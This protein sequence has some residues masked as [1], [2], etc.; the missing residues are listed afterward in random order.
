MERFRTAILFLGAVYALLPPPVASAHVMQPAGTTLVQD[1]GPYRLAL[2]MSL[3]S[4]LPSPLSVQVAPEQPFPGVVAITIALVS[5]GASW[6]TLTPAH[7]ISAQGTVF[8]QFPIA[9]PGDYEL[10][11]QAAGQ[12][13]SAE[14]RVPITAAQPPAAW[15]AWL[16]PAGLGM[17]VLFLGGAGVLSLAMHRRRLLVSART[18]LALTGSMAISAFVALV[19]LVATQFI[20]ATATTP[21]STSVSPK[22][23]NVNAEVH[24]DVNPIGAG[25]PMD[26]SIALTNGTGGQ[27]VDDVVPNHNALMH[28][29]IVSA[30]REFFQHAYPARTAPGRYLATFSPD[31]PGNYTAYVEVLRQTDSAPQVFARTLSVGADAASPAG[32]ATGDGEEVSAASTTSPANI[33]PGLPAHLTF[34][35]SA[36]GRPIGLAPFLDTAADI[37]VVS[38]DGGVFGHIPATDLATGNLLD[39]GATIPM[40]G[41]TA[42]PLGSTVNFTCTFP[43]AGRY[44]LW[45][46]AKRADSGVVITASKWLDVGAAAADGSTP[47]GSTAPL[48]S[49]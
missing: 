3:A 46:G 8:A 24:T 26:L 11:L 36:S 29:F 6:P 34:R 47:G 20:P 33:R 18:N 22:G 35:F 27:L 38:S 2:T 32:S 30:D 10:L 45:V 28:V 44:K 1:L 39:G 9:N 5:A 7:V 14:A 40:S 48:T 42:T 23:S 41:P 37:V 17:F 49:V 4:T 31:R 13:G 12:D 19:A 25:H 16:V 15:L 21:Q 43:A